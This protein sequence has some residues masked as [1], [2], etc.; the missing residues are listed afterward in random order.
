MVKSSSK[1][2]NLV[3]SIRRVKSLVKSSLNQGP[4][5]R[6]GHCGPL[7]QVFYCSVCV[8]SSCE[9]LNIFCFAHKPCTKKLHMG[10][11]LFFLHW[12]KWL[13]IVVLLSQPS[14]QTCEMSKHLHRQH[15]ERQSFTPKTREFQHMPNRNRTLEIMNKFKLHIG[16]F[17]RNGNFACFV[18]FF[19]KCNKALRR[20][21]AL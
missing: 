13:S 18:I 9:N 1:V 2:I 7:M 15:F 6:K 11:I 8:F 16:K 10:R 14:P 4:A 3:Q 21:F 19:E 12:P 5:R 20:H 17:P